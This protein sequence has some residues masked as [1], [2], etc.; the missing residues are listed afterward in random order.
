MNIYEPMNKD[1]QCYTQ[2]LKYQKQRKY[3]YYD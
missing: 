3:L 1:K 2:S